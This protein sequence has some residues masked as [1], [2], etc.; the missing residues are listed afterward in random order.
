MKAY[1]QKLKLRLSRIQTSFGV[2]SD[3]LMSFIG[4]KQKA[5]LPLILI[6]LLLAIILGII[7][8]SS[9][10]APFVYPLF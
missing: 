3:V 8:S 4:L 7:S 2:I 9:F 5:V 1:T 6:L 10:L